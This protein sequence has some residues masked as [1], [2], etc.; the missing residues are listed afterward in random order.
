MKVAIAIA[1]SVLLTSVAHAQPSCMAQSAEKKLAGAAQKSFMTKCEADA[2]AA[3]EVGGGEEAAGAAKDSF[4]KKCVR[5]RWAWKA[6]PVLARR[7]C[8]AA[9]LLK[10][11]SLDQAPRVDQVGA[12][13]LLAPIWRAGV[14]N[15]A[16]PPS[17]RQPCLAQDRVREVPVG[18]RHRGGPPHVGQN[19]GFVG[20]LRGHTGPAACMREK[21]RQRAPSGTFPAARREPA[22]RERHRTP[23]VEQPD[24][25]QYLGTSWEPS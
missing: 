21:F 1:A 24:L 4:T 7:T 22:K 23:R 15:D 16:L 25:D 13:A 3:C 8:N 6:S 19:V 18:G 12:Q 11:R 17:R 20:H 9:A 2:K 10:A 5:A 14:S